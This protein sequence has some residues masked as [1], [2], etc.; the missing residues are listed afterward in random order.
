M[1]LS[2]P[3]V[4]Y[5]GP[6]HANIGGVESSMFFLSP[7]LEQFF[8][9]DVITHPRNPSRKK[10][11]RVGGVPVIATPGRAILSGVAV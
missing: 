9:S 7:I 10:V 2:I 6:Y 4:F 1:K 11:G 5:I 8:P 3:A